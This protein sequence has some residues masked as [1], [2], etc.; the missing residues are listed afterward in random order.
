MQLRD[1][2]DNSDLHRLFART[3][4]PFWGGVIVVTLIIIELG[5]WLLP[6]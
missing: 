5:N 2:K 4:F 3:F 1:P 6:V